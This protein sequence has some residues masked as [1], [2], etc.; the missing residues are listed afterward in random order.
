MR[1]ATLT[2]LKIGVRMQILDAI[3]LT[4]RVCELLSVEAEC[5]KSCADVIRW[6]MA[7]AD[8]AGSDA[9][10]NE[11]RTSPCLRLLF[12]PWRARLLFEQHSPLG[13]ASDWAFESHR[14]SVGCSVIRR[15]ISHVHIHARP[16]DY[17]AHTGRLP[18]KTSGM[19]STY[20]T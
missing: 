5:I 19:Y 17:V 10:L 12:R 3:V 4:Q 18:D 20:G 7:K 15:V 1:Y 14:T 6:R 13:C 11:S 9:A 8:L 16:G 2:I